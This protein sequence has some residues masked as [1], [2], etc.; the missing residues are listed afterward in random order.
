MEPK[1]KVGDR[2]IVGCRYAED[3]SSEVRWFVGKVATVEKVSVAATQYIIKIGSARAA[4]NIY[5][6]DE[7]FKKSRHITFNFGQYGKEDM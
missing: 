7:L 3:I 4:V 6:A 5:Y 1:Y 2:V